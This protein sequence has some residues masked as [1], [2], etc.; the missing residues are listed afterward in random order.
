MRNLF[1]V[2]SP[3]FGTAYGL[4]PDMSASIYLYTMQFGTEPSLFQELNK[5]LRTENRQALKP[6]FPFLKLFLSASH[7]L[8]ARA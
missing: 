3:L 8:P 4:T 6:W 5:T 2:I 1:I 7:T